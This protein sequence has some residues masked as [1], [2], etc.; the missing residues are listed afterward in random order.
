MENDLNKNTRT[1]IVSFVIAIMALIPLRFVEVSNQFGGK[2]EVLGDTSV[3]YSAVLEA[4]YNE[5]ESSNSSCLDNE[6]AD[7][8]VND[9]I[10]QLED[11]SVSSVQKDEIVSSIQI[12]EE[13]RCK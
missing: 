8:M 5:M 12:V 4:P 7:L 10:T 3:G 13:N 6:Q 11:K 9:Y 2:S 1:L